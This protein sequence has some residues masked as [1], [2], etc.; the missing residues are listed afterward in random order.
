MSPASGVAKERNG[1][2]Q[3]QKMMMENRQ[4]E[5]SFAVTSHLHGHF[6]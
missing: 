1:S 3:M 5:N 2:L 6:K 4:L